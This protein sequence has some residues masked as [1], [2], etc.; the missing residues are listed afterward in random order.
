MQ[1]V[2]DNIVSILHRNSLN[3][4]IFLRCYELKLDDAF[5]SDE[6]I[7]DTFGDWTIVGGIDEVEQAA[8]W[9]EI[10]RRILYC[11]RFKI[12]VLNA[13]EAAITSVELAGFVNSLR[14]KACDR[15]AGAARRITDSSSRPPRF[16]F[17]SMRQ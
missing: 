7:E 10:R 6:L 4:R 14:Q 5:T 17:R 1:D 11:E 9:I 8:A 13:A 12:V 2:L 3:Y 16:I 15:G